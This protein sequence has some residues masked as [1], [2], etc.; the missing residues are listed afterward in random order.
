MTAKS[1]EPTAIKA[2]AGGRHH[3][4]DHQPEQAKQAGCKDLPL[5]S[6]TFANN[7]QEAVSSR[8]RK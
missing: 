8:K 1:Q 7:K 2:A 3:Q 5:L 6:S 4:P